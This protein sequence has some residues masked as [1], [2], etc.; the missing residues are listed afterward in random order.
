M[1]SKRPLLQIPAVVA[2]WVKCE[3]THACLY[4]MT[5]FIEH[6]H[7]VWHFTGMFLHVCKCVCVHVCG[8]VCMYTCVW[9]CTCLCLCVR[10]CVY[11]N[12]SAG[13]CVCVSCTCHSVHVDVR[14][15]TCRSQ[16]SPSTMWI[17]VTRPMSSVLVTSAFVLWAISI[18][19]RYNTSNNIKL[20]NI[21]ALVDSFD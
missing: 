14:E 15:T 8:C 1:A 21:P 17:W 9:V 4:A 7:M 13:V 19:H 18:G 11:V 2:S 10:V 5:E 12:V 20:P 6:S 3:W 16:L